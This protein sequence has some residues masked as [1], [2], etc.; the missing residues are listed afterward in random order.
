[1]TTVPQLDQQTESTMKQFREFL[2]SYNKLSE[3]CFTDCVHDFTTRK[4]LD[5]EQNCTTNCMDKYLK[6]TQRISQRFQEAQ[7]QQNDSAKV[8][9][10]IS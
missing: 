7:M 8:H 5:S 9:S 10:L 2:L 4:V 6:I 3:M 1:M